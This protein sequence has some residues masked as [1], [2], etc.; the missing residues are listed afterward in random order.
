MGEQSLEKEVR[1]KD[2]GKAVQAERAI[3]AG[4]HYFA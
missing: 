2:R 1:S 3:F 4:L